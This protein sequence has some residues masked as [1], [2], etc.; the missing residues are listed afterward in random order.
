[1][2][3]FFT[4]FLILLFSC[5]AF[6]QIVETKDG[7]I[8]K[9]EKIHSNIT[10]GTVD[11]YLSDGS[12][13][14]LE[15]KNVYKI[16]TR[17]FSKLFSKSTKKFEFNAALGVL[18]YHYIKNNIIEDPT[19]NPESYM[20]GNFSINI[21]ATY[22]LSNNL[23]IGFGVRSRPKRRNSDFN[24]HATSPYFSLRYKINNKD[25]LS[26]LNLSLHVGYL[27]RQS[28][29]YEYS[30]FYKRSF[31]NIDQEQYPYI[32]EF[33][34]HKKQKTINPNSF[35]LNPSISY[36]F[37]SKT[38]LH[39]VVNF[40]CNIFQNEY[41]SEY[42]H[43]ENELNFISRVDY[44][45]LYHFYNTPDFLTANGIPTTPFEESQWVLAPYFSL[46]VQY[47]L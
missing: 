30:N 11:I 13:I 42:H 44:N 9:A 15:E 37:R 1:M 21:Q 40:G 39:F 16:R 20:E 24:A 35:F 2:P 47:Q 4:I 33:H 38:A 8:Y 25:Y 19:S 28:S 29:W 31:D 22:L 34:L 32:E 41:I 17:K 12:K 18:P 5:S 3:K 26:G 7:I 36:V 43:T 45:H 27:F 23:G 6:A 14:V 46:G 10:E